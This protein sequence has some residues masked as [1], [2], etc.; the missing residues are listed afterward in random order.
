[1]KSWRFCVDTQG[2][3]PWRWAGMPGW[4][5]NLLRWGKKITSIYMHPYNPV[6]LRVRFL[7]IIEWSSIM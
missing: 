6:I 7:K 3:F 1:M 2:L 5:G 4:G